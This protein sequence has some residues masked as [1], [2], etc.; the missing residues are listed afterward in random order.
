MLLTRLGWSST[1]VITGD[2]GQSDL[3]PELSGLANVADRLAAVANV[4]VVRLADTDIVR[5]PLVGEM[6]AVL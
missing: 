3:L 2:P 1:M 5:H 6:L 4:A